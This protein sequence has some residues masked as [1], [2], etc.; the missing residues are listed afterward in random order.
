MNKRSAEETRQKILA[1]AKNV[2]TECGYAQ[3][4]MRIIASAAGISVGGIYLYFK[5]KEDL[6]LT[7]MQDW[8]AKLNDR[9]QEVM[10]KIDNP[11]EA[12]TAYIEISIDFATKHKEVIM[13]QGR[14]L[15]FSFGIDLKRDFFRER[16]RRIAEIV[17]KGIGIG[18]FRPCDADAA[19]KVIFS[20][21]RGFIVSMVID[22]EALFAPGECVNLVLHGLIREG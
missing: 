15:G 8:M 5:N 6:Y 2:F 4:N 7:F 18:V 22:E 12:I 19:A 1:A 13:L 9:T 10:L 16:R 14:E 20:I 17:R 3:A 11:L 21:L